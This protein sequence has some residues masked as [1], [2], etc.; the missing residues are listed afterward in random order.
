[1]PTHPSHA[2]P[3]PLPAPRHAQQTSLRASLHRP[4]N[5][6]ILPALRRHLSAATPPRTRRLVPLLL[7]LLALIALASCATSTGGAAR[8]AANGTSTA[9]T[10]VAFP[11][12]AYTADVR[13]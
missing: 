5:A 4:F 3:N 7:P 10:E 1:M 2:F 13:S 12:A 6:A 8:R 11:P 9:T